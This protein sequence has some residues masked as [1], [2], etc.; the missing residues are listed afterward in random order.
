MMVMSRVLTLLMCF[1]LLSS[2]SYRAHA[3]TDPQGGFPIRPPP[4]PPP[5]P[6]DLDDQFEEVQEDPGQ[7]GQFIPA[8][9][10]PRNDDGN[11]GPPP[12][13]SP[14]PTSRPSGGSNS[15]S[16]PGTNGIQFQIVEGEF[17]VRGK[18]RSRGNDRR[19][20]E[21]SSGTANSG[22]ANSGTAIPDIDNSF[23]ENSDAPIPDYQNIPDA[24][25]DD[26]QEPDDMMYDEGD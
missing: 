1:L 10:P 20:A 24:P 16:K 22:T 18:R 6:N 11:A 26:Y 12:P 8:I 25:P 5:A 9:P 21:G 7:P 15:F 17:Y 14:T 2:P 3:Q 13:P 23:N 19:R 4:P